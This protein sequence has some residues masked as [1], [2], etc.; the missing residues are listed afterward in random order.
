M[1]LACTACANTFADFQIERVPTRYS[2]NAKASQ[3]V[4]EVLITNY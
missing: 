2:I 1:V 3:A 4:G